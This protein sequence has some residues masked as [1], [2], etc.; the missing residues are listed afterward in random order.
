MAKKKTLLDEIHELEPVLTA[1]PGPMSWAGKLLQANPSLY[2]EVQA[3]L[4]QWVKDT[5][6]KG[7][8]LK[9]P[10]AKRLWEFL[11]T[12][13]DPFLDRPLE[14]GPFLKYLQKVERNAKK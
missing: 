6:A 10:Q 4:I 1:M 13:I 2:E 11:A 7:L 9:F 12:K 5:P 3:V 8:K 14:Y